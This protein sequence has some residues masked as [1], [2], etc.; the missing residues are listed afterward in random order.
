MNQ[1]TVSVQNVQ[2]AVTFYQNLGL[3]LIVQSPHYARFVC[4]NGL[5]TFS[6]HEHDG[7]VPPSKT[8]VYFECQNLDQHVSSLLDNG[9]TFDQ[10]PKD[11]PWDWREAYLR[12]PSGNLICLYKAGEVRVNPSWRIT[13]S[14]GAYTLTTTRL[15]AWLENL[16]HVLESS[17]D[18]ELKQL[19]T[20]EVRFLESPLAVPVFGIANLKNHWDNVMGSFATVTFKAIGAQDEVG[21]A[22]LEA[23]WGTAENV[24]Y[25]SILA[26]NFNAAG[27]CTGITTW[28]GPTISR[29]VML[30]S[31]SGQ[32]SKN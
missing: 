17:R 11:Q 1:V 25:S 26:L 6:V 21:Y 24:V 23:T 27:F 16:Q 3:H 19:F 5:A 7:P 15:T 28:G 14:K 2:D 9:Y 12:D 22:Q 29:E 8:T 31:V 13:E 20:S 18:E 10:M 32:F 4:P 30:K